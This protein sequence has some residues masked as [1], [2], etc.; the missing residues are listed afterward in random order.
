VF[1]SWDSGTS[2]KDNAFE[3]TNGGE[4]S[5]KGDDHLKPPDPND[6]VQQHV[7]SGNGGGVDDEMVV[8][9]PPSRQ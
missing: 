9:T 3:I 2:G 8:E 4:K 5:S 1:N 6:K 7:S